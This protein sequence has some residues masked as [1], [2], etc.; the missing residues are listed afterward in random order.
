MT[1][2][3]FE[4]IDL[5]V[6]T[7]CETIMEAVKEHKPDFLCLSGLI[8]PSLEEMAHVAEEMEANGFTIPLMVGGATTSKIHT[9]VKIAPHYSG[10]VIHGQD[11]SDSVTILMKLTS[12]STKIRAAE[13]YRSENESRRDTYYNKVQKVLPYTEACA[14]KLITEWQQAEISVPA[15]LGN[16]LLMDI[17]IQTLKQYINWTFFFKAWEIKGHYPEVLSDPLKGV[18]SY[19]PV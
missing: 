16:R 2:N 6:M 8:T 15:N 4:V 11:A 7:P 12:E 13:E 1:C 19:K 14:N 3:N 9:A 10:L 17:N 18:G 5:G